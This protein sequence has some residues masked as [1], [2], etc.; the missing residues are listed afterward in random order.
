MLRPSPLDIS[1]L[2]AG[3]FEAL[4]R[5]FGLFVLIALFPSLVALVVIGGGV[6][7]VATAAIAAGSFTRGVPA[8]VLAGIVVLVIGA[9]ATV[10]AQAKAQGMTALGA[11]EIAQGQHPDLRGLLR[12]TRGFLPRMAPVIAIFAGAVLLTYGLVLG[13]VFAMVGA[14][15]GSSGGRA[16]A[17]A[18]VLILLAFALVPVAI[19]LQVKLLYTVPAV[20]IEERGGMDAM[21]RSWG[22]TRGAFWRTLGYY[23]L[24]GVAAAA[25]GYVVSMIGQFA[26]MPA[27]M[28]VERTG[29]PSRALAAMFALLPLYGVVIGLQLAV[30]LLTQPFVHAYTT[31]MFVDQVRR[32]EMPP[33]PAYGGYPPGTPGGYY[34]PPAQYYGQPPQ[35]YPAGGWQQPQQ[36]QQSYPPQPPP[37]QPPQAGPSGE[38]DRPP[39]A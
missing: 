22:L 21:K 23:L 33:A 27:M 2:F 35:G 24:V 17:L 12:R 26:L 32:S 39:P 4:K 28:R 19:F 5:R 14:L 11:Y 15:D 20:A 31:Y 38:E 18:G 8:G 13:I 16:A 7:I 25:V 1:G 36:P 37:P 30:Q 10:L 9:L 34:A 6:A 3:S 29:D